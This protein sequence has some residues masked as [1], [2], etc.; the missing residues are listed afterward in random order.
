MEISKDF[1]YKLSKGYPMTA[2]E[3]LKKGYDTHGLTGDE[4][5]YEV[6]LENGNIYWET[7]DDFIETLKRTRE[8]N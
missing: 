5:G 7:I 1:G 3:A 8:E 2:K 6:Y 4:K